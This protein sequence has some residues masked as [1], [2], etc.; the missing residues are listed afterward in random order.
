[1]SKSGW[2]TVSKPRDAPRTPAG[3]AGNGPSRVYFP[4]T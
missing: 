4:Q 2:L 3:L 1:M